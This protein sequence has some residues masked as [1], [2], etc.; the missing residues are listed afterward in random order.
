MTRVAAGTDLVAVGN[1][2]RVVVAETPKE[3]CGVANVFAL[4]VVEIFGGL[5]FGGCWGLNVAIVGSV[6]VRIV[7]VGLAVAALGCAVQIQRKL[8]NVCGH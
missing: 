5:L 1:R 2:V 6:F 4:E 8:G 3:V 7:L